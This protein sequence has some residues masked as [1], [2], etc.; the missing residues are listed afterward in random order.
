MPL[1]NRPVLGIVTRGSVVAIL[2]VM[3]LPSSVHLFLATSQAT[4]VA[5]V[6][7]LA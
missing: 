4:G 5:R 6:A 7:L 1:G 3:L 2:A